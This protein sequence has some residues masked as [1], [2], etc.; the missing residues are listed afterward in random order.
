MYSNGIQQYK[1]L[2]FNIL[3]MFSSEENMSIALIL[4]APILP[5]ATEPTTVLSQ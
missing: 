3:G 4:R 1:D 5:V 2:G